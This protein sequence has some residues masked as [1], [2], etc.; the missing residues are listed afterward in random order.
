ML[1]HSTRYRNNNSWLEGSRS[2][3][4]S[5][6]NQD[7]EDDRTIQRSDMLLPKSFSRKQTHLNK[8]EQVQGDSSMPQAPEVVVIPRSR[9]SFPDYDFGSRARPSSRQQKRSE[10]TRSACIFCETGSESGNEIGWEHRD[11]SSERE[12]EKRS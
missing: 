1:L 7:L 6:G 11:D 2:I 4:G 9:R 12:I 8:N 3:S 10:R 5:D